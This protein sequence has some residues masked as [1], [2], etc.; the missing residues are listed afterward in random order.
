MNY[1]IAV[2]SLVYLAAPNALAKRG[3]VFQDTER[4]NPNSETQQVQQP[5][6]NNFFYPSVH[7]EGNAET[8]K[9]YPEKEAKPEQRPWYLTPEW[10]LVAITLILA[11][12]S[13]YTAFIMR[14][15]AR[16]Q[17]RAYVWIEPKARE[18]T[19]PFLT[20][21]G[22]DE[23]EI[24]IKNGGITPAYRVRFWHKTDGVGKGDVYDF[25]P[26]SFEDKA[27]VGSVADIFMNNPIKIKTRARKLPVEHVRGMRDGSVVFYYWGEL[28]YF[29]AFEK[30]RRTKWRYELSSAHSGEWRMCQE[31]NEST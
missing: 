1:F 24:Y 13:Y 5:A 15:T 12:L 21:I 4:K 17:L 2:I 9:T 10:D 16:R 29:D 27:I 19:T 26:E 30:E 22:T 25:P 11:L 8:P 23:F 31:G 14:D 6:Q 28:R 18:K 7:G 20:D 3:K